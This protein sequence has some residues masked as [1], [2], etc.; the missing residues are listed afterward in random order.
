[1]LIVCVRLPSCLLCVGALLRVASVRGSV[2]VSCVLPGLGGLGCVCCSFLLYLR[3][4]SVAVAVAGVVILSCCGRRCWECIL[5]A[6]VAVCLAVLSLLVRSAASLR[7][8]RVAVVVLVWVSWVCAGLPCWVLPAVWV[9]GGGAVRVRVCRPWWLAGCSWSCACVGWVPRVCAGRWRF[10]SY[11]L[12]L[13]LLGRSPRELSRGGVCNTHH[14][15]LCVFLL[16][17]RAF[18][19]YVSQ[20]MFDVRRVRDFFCVVDPFLRLEPVVLEPVLWSP[21]RGRCLLFS[22]VL[23]SYAN[24]R[25]GTES[26]REEEREKSRRR[27]RKTPRGWG[28]WK[29]EAQTCLPP[30]GNV[31]VETMGNLADFRICLQVTGSGRIEYMGRGDC[32]P[33]WKFGPMQGLCQGILATFWRLM[34]KVRIHRINR[35]KLNR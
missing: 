26:K 30:V 13:R 34:C 3:L 21:F 2:L 35:R 27:S 11:A 28:E 29:W 4:T 1:M 9:F 33:S 10:V 23:L 5:P 16:S 19:S 31:C 17:L 32:F 18:I 12:S 22:G 7:V 6:D 8:W 24:G 15:V 14:N 25:S 20:L